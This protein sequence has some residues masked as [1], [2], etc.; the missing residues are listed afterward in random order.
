[1]KSKI[2]FQKCNFNYIYFLL[3]ILSFMTMLIIENYLY[4]DELKKRAQ[5]NLCYFANKEMIEIFTFNL[6]DFIAIIPYF[7][8]KKLV[9]GNNDNNEYKDILFIFNICI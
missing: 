4:S 7:I 5:N 2:I 8:R 3:Y 9:Q 1:M 6:A